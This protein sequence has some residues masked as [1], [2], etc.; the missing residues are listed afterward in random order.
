[1]KMIYN[2]SRWWK[3]MENEDDLQSIKDDERW[4]KMIENEDDL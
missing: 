3:M 2:A 4:L 1:M